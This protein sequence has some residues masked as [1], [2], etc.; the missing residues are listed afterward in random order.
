MAEE[1]DGKDSCLLSSLDDGCLANSA[2]VSAGNE[3]NFSRRKPGSKP[4]S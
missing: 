3:T 2:S 1:V 4:P